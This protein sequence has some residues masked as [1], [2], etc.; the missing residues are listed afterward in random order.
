MNLIELDYSFKN[1]VVWTKK[2]RGKSNRLTNYELK[3]LVVIG[4]VYVVIT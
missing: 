3:M 4:E 1:K 2:K